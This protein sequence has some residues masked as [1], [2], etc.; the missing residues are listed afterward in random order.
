MGEVKSL[1]NAV[2]SRS[3]LPIG[4]VVYLV[5]EKDPFMIVSCE[6]KGREDEV[7]VWDYLG[8][9]YPDGCGVAGELTAFDRDHVEK[10][11]FVGYQG[12]LGALKEEP[13]VVSQN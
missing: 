12:S 11:L 9:P 2:I 8:C 1:N 10:L 7:R 5:E 6:Q 3:L 4:S 13:P